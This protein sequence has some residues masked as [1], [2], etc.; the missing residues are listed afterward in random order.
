MLKIFSANTDIYYIKHYK[1]VKLTTSIIIGLK[2]WKST[3]ATYTHLV[4]ALH[5]YVSLNLVV[6]Q[7]VETR[8]YIFFDKCVCG[9][10]Y[11]LLWYFF[12]II[13]EFTG[14]MFNK[15]DIDTDLSSS[16]LFN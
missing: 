11:H 2:N 15:H 12:Y 4:K 6:S 13:V 9:G 7:I 14:A 10:N 1:C 16:E 5:S 3:S 8:G